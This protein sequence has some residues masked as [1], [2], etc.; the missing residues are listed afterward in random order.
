LRDFRIK[1]QRQLGI[2]FCGFGVEAPGCFQVLL[3]QFARH[4][5]GNLV[6][7]AALGRNAD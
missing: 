2:I 3:S 5:D 1:D 4:G 7:A 6:A